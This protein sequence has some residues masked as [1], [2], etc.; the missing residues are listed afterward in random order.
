MKLSHLEYFSAVCRLGSTTQAAAVLSI[1]QPAISA[2]IRDLENEFGVLL[3]VRE[4]KRLQITD[5]GKK[6]YDL[7]QDI[8][9]RTEN[10]V[11]VMNDLARNRNRLSLGITPML[12]CLFLPNLFETF[13]REYPEVRFSV[14]EG[15]RQHLFQKLDARELHMVICSRN[16]E[17]DDGYR[18]MRLME[19]RLGICLHRDHPLAK[20]DRVSF[21]DLRDEP[22]AGFSL[23]FHQNQF[24]ERKFAET[25]SSPRIIFRTSQ[26]STMWEMVSH[27]LVSCFMYTALSRH[28]PDLRF[29]PLDTDDDTFNTTP[30]N[31]YWRKDDF[32]Y[33][34]MENLIQCIKAM[35]LDG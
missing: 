3:F 9:S 26:I 20:K 18:K 34:D 21:H 6:L 32:L 23:G 33:R 30:I 12:A 2:A 16:R 35:H 29:L 27:G 5:A 14:F 28:R 31:L 11:Q 25:G 19:L 1:S 10:A 15:G 7:S 22:L 8:L 4:G 24:I 17:L 13:C